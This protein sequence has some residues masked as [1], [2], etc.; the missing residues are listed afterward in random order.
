MPDALQPATPA[1]AP[2]PVPADAGPEGAQGAPPAP[3]APGAAESPS[4]S[5]LP[6]LSFFS[7]DVERLREHFHTAWHKYEP[8]REIAWF[9]LPIHKNPFDVFQYQEIISQQRPEFVIECGAYLGGSTLYFAHLL[10]LVGHGTVISIDLANCWEPQVLAH[11]RVRALAGSSVDP[12]ILSRVRQLVP[13]GASCLVVLD[14][15]HRA[16]HV[17]AELRAYQEFV[18]VGNYLVVEDTNLNGHP[19]STGWGPGPFEAVEAFLKEDAPFVPDRWR[20]RK[21]FMTFAPSG[22][23]RRVAEPI[24]GRWL[25]TPRGV[26]GAHA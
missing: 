23:L 24:A 21:L 11:P 18:Q 16:E 14:S 2:A 10:D 5:L 25:R 4:D 3:P 7:P 6:D 12:Q 17:L 26:G 22:W 13:P 1:E 15:D 19:V 20:E 9:G 8:W